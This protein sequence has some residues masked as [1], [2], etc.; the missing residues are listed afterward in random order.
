M[1]KAR[2][3][4]VL[5]AL[6]FAAT[7]PAR[8]QAPATAPGTVLMSNSLASVTQAEY[9]A[10]I[11]KLP[12]DLR[13][14]FSNNPRRVNDLLVRMLVQKSLATQARA[15]KLDV[16][17]DVATRLALEVD[18]FLAGI[19]VERIEAAANAEFDA[20]IAR[21]EARARELYLVD[22][23]RFMT[24]PQVSATHILFDTKKHGSDAAK[25]LALDA[26]AKIAAGADMAKLAREVSE[27]PTAPNNGGALGFFSEKEMDPG[28]G[29][30]AFALAKPGD[31]SEPVQSQFGWHIIRLDDKRPSTLKTY[32]QA[33]DE[34]MAA[35]RKR[36]A[37]QKREE[38]IAAV[39]R[40]PKTEVNRQAVDALTPKVDPETIRRA[41][42]TAPT[43]PPAVTPK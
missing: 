38:A 25:K 30:A 21:Q 37:D 5:L 36:N 16:R 14:G 3:A 40:D 8:A 9:D 28:F 18:R 13:E 26:R 12:P 31:L 20:S 39:R 7:G 33:R 24:A 34:I 19:E 43:A 29:A 10:E 2:L 41:Q 1:H 27:D 23:A 6:A 11:K 17:P 15:A 35:L 42:E 4:I 22:K 32:E